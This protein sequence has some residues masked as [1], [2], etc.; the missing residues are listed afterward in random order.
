MTMISFSNAKERNLWLE[1]R[2]ALKGSRPTKEQLAEYSRL[3][4]SERRQYVKKLMDVKVDGDAA[5]VM[6]PAES[7]VK[8]RKNKK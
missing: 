2:R 3:C 7:T 5:P 4:P 1:M 6:V 8:G